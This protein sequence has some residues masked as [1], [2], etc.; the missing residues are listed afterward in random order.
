MQTGGKSI[1][2]DLFNSIPQG[3]V[4]VVS[5]YEKIMK[6]LVEE[7]GEVEFRA[8]SNEALRTN[9]FDRYVPQTETKSRFE[10]QKSMMSAA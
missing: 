7:G 6:F 1:L 10:D 2:N 5:I 4:Q 8:S 3:E 9:E